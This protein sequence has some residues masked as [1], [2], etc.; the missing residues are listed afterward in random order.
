ML[1]LPYLPH[2]LE[3]KQML[4]YDECLAMC[5]LTQGEVSAIAEHEHLDPMIAL[6]VGQYLCCHDGEQKIK[7]IIIDDIEHAEKVGN[8]AHAD[9]LKRVLEHFVATHP[10]HRSVSAA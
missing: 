3:D 5:D 6:A 7:R 4:T 2:T 9:V 10:E 8:T 1:Y